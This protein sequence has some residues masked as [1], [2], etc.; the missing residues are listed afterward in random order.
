MA[1]AFKAFRIITLL[2]IFLSLAFYAKTQKLKSRSWVTPLDVVIYP[3]N[4]DQS[5]VVQ[6][7]ISQLDQSVFTEI[8]R[9]FQNEAAHYQLTLVQPV[10]TQLGSIIETYPPSAPSANASFIE[11]ILWSI[12]FRYWA[13]QHTPDNQS[14][15]HRVRVFI[16]FHE[17]S[18]HTQLQHSLG[19]DK[20]LLSIVHAFAS[21]E[22]ESQNNIVIAHELLHTVG[23]TDK[24]NVD[25]QSVFPDGYAN[26]EQ[27]P[28]FPQLQAEIM[29]G[30]IPLSSTA[31][32]MAES[33]QDC[34]IGEKTAEEINW[35]NP[36][37][38]T[39]ND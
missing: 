24:Y 33:L 27:K 1:V 13:Y 10:S 11:T 19:L 22:Q 35:L 8:D 17:A 3:M 31:S 29:S 2:L 28:L 36:K 23:A 38:I 21:K 14:N 26:P 6:N 18:E 4:S 12:K 34:I 9:F 30:R 20:G 5:V 32:K 39:N 7:Y 16:H 15:L 37:S 25:N